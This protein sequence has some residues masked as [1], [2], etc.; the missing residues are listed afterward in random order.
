M[1]G[2]PHRG[3]ATKRRVIYWVGSFALFSNCAADRVVTGTS[4]QVL[5]RYSDIPMR[6]PEATPSLTPRGGV[7]FLVGRGGG[8][9]VA[10]ARAL[11][12]CARQQGVTWAEDIE[13]IDIGYLIESFLPG[14]RGKPRTSGFDGDE[15]YNWLMK[16]GLYR[17]AALCG[18]LALLGASICH[19]CIMQGFEKFWQTREPRLVCSFIPF[20]N[21]YFRQSLLRSGSRA[22]LFTVCTD[23]ETNRAHRWIPKYDSQWSTRHIIVAAQATFGGNAT[24]SATLKRTYYRRQEWS[25]IPRS[26]HHPES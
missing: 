9:H 19:G 18:P 16:K 20:F 26:H 10:S 5:L 25:C 23:F 21:G 11:Q 22:T 8:G 3:T 12:V 6:S 17:L 14:R 13:L 2:R 24:S 1:C 15:L 4:D 7:L